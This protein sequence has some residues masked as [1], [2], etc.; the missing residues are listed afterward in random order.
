MKITQAFTFEAAHRLPN[1]PETHRCFRMHGH[2]YRIELTLEGP[3][4]PR[5]GFVIDFFDVEAVFAPLL[6]RLDHHCLNEVE[7]LEN[8]TAE[9]IAIWI[10]QRVKPLLPLV[11]SVRVYETPQ[12]WAEYEGV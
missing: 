11:S 1:V 8:P 9:H 2:S 3:V 10:W 7:G 12:S 5:S 6:E 4:D